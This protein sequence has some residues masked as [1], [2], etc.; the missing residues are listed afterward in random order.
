MVSDTSSTDNPILRQL[1][2]T[3]DQCKPLTLQLVQVTCYH[4]LMVSQYLL[5]QQRICRDQCLQILARIHCPA[6]HQI[7]TEDSIFMHKP[8]THYAINMDGSKD[9]RGRRGDIDHTFWR[10]RQSLDRIV[11]NVIG[12]REQHISPLQRSNFV[13]I[14]F[15]SP[16]S[17][18][19][20]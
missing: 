3:R 8:R 9:F 16:L 18:D 17:G 19:V 7:V 13:C 10:K 5:I 2:S 4:Q 1:Q 15:S 20:T 11:P 14:P 12:D 6:V